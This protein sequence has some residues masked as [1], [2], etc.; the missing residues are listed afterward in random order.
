[1]NCPLC[2][3]PMI[4]LELNEVE[5]DHCLTCRGTWLD[6]GELELLL[7][8][9][10]NKERLLAALDVD[11]STDEAPRRCPICNKKMRK[12]RSGPDER[13]VIDKCKNNDG[14]WFDHG[15]LREIIASGDFPGE[16]Q[17]FELLKDVFGDTT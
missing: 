3:K 10:E 9:A 4:V 13:V 5:V 17:V 8:G 7:D 6:A 12:V 16:H 1:M 14:L 15:E 2:D 11:A